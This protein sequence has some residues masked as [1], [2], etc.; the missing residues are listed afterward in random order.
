MDAVFLGRYKDKLFLFL[1]KSF[2]VQE[3]LIAGF[4]G[5]FFKIYDSKGNVHQDISL[6]DL[7]IVMC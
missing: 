2:F 5:P 6:F 3:S 4:A 1:I 7:D